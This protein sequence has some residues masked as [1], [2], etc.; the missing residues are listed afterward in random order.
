MHTGCRGNGYVGEA[1][2]PADCQRA[3]GQ[4]AGLPANLTIKRQNSV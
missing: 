3:V 4:N 1:R 2:V